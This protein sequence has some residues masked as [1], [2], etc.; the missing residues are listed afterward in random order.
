MAEKAESDEE[1]VNEPSPSE[2]RAAGRR[3]SAAAHQLA[4]H[5]TDVQKRTFTRW[6]N[7][8]LVRGKT[9]VKVDDVFKD[10]RSGV[11]LQ[12]L[13]GVLAPEAKFT[14][15]KGKTRVHRISNVNA[16][17]TFLRRD[18]KLKLINIDAEDLVEGKEKLTLGL[19]WALIQHY[20][21]ADGGGGSSLEQKK[22]LIA[23]CQE[24]VNDYRDVHVTD[25][26][27]SWRNGMA[28]NALLHFHKA[29]VVDYDSLSASNA[30]ENLE[31]AFTKAEK[32][33]SVP[34][35]LDPVDV[36]VK[37]PDERSIMTYLVLLRNELQPLRESAKDTTDGEDQKKKSDDDA[38]R[39]ELLRWIGLEKEHTAQRHAE[40]P[41]RDLL[42]L[43]AALKELD[44]EKS[45]LN[46]KESEAEE[47]GNAD[48]QEKFKELLDSIA[49]YR[50]ALKAAMDAAIAA[51]NDRIKLAKDVEELTRWAQE[52]SQQFEQVDSLPDDWAMLC[53]LKEEF[54]GHVSERRPPREVQKSEASAL[55]D[56]VHSSP[57]M[58]NDES[59]MS[60]IEEQN[61]SLER[62]WSGM[63]DNQPIY[64]AALSAKIDKLRQDAI[65]KLDGRRE[66]TSNWIAAVSKQMSAE[67][68]TDEAQ[69]EALM[70]EFQKLEIGELLEQDGI[71]QQVQEDTKQL[72]VD[73]VLDSSGASDRHHASE[74]SWKKLKEDRAEYWKR[75]SAALHA[76]QSDRDALSKAEQLKEWMRQK[77]AVFSV[78]DFPSDVERLKMLSAQHKAQYQEGEFPVHDGD[79]TSIVQSLEQHSSAENSTAKECLLHDWQ[80]MQEEEKIY[81]A[82]LGRAMD[83]S[84]AADAKRQA[85]LSA[86]LEWATAKCFEF[87]SAQEK[88]A[89][90]THPMPL[91]EQLA[92]LVE[93]DTTEK[94]AKVTEFDSLT[95]TSAP[96]PHSSLVQEVTA[97]WKKVNEE[98][99]S[100][101]SL[102]EANLAKQ[103]QAEMDESARRASIVS[104]LDAWIVQKLLDFSTAGL[105]GCRKTELQGRLQV[106]DHSYMR[107]ELPP[108]AAQFSDVCGGAGQPLS[109]R[110]SALKVQ[111]EAYRTALLAVIAER[112]ALL[113]DLERWMNQCT[114]Q[115]SNHNFP[116]DRSALDNLY[117]AGQQFEAQE[118]KTRDHQLSQLAGICRPDAE[119]LMPAWKRLVENVYPQYMEALQTAA[120]AARTIEELRAWTE[121]QLVLFQTESLVGKRRKELQALLIEV[122][123]YEADELQ[124]KE[125]LKAS[126]PGGAAMSD[127]NVK[128][129][130]M[131]G[132][133]NAYKAAL[134]NTNVESD[135]EGMS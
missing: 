130:E 44:D 41:A 121:A 104:A 29:E 52:R 3:T 94:V 38:A 16:V 17:L 26:T 45:T 78:T 39:D 22:A 71:Q 6:V 80:A 98:E 110:W 77:R 5:A 91:D 133:R 115:M 99:S 103:R 125:E 67:L 54:A 31:G 73:G 81:V 76:A 86:F 105:N 11:I 128:W 116:D 83:D 75:L 135:S 65:Q 15:E 109:D 62:A 101:R 111:Q 51:D 46:G 28:F 134:Q 70:D 93:Y 108:R 32:H 25:L 8:Q 24:C 87:T 49:T 92:K 97:A 10:L 14:R 34:Q 82:A 18:A 9:G 42:A 58:A 12:K 117:A 113:S 57:A 69:L 63:T 7:A 89:S 47:L 37:S 61:N 127:L 107:E 96:A 106:F 33:F 114:A 100:Y 56:S 50:A 19:L 13:V 126:L 131:N 88:V 36:N 68:P 79:R 30:E 85:Q 43:R 72:G 74:E 112:D 60:S 90:G 66:Q 120:N 64:E 119:S 1:L 84:L 4:E 122:E 2:L 20:Q 95:M 40:V 118:I 35:L 55:F 124:K 48:V 102:L 23:W 132:A 21:L 53:Q 123:R 129:R 27:K 59:V